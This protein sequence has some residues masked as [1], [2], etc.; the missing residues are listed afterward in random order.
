MNNN[1][2]KTIFGILKALSIGFVCIVQAQT[3]IGLY[4]LA[5]LRID[6]GLCSDCA[7]PKQAL[8]YFKNELIAT[9]T[10]AERMAGFSITKNAQQDLAENTIAAPPPLIWLGS[11]DVIEDTRLSVNVSDGELNY[12]E[13]NGNLEDTLWLGIEDKIATNLSFWDKTTTTFFKDKNVSLRG[14]IA[15]SGFIARTVWPK[16]FKLD[17]NEKLQPLNDNQNLKSLVQFENGGAK[18]AYEARLLWGDASKSQGHAVLGMI[19]NGA[20]GDDDEAHGGHFAIATGRI[21]LEGDMSNWLVNNY[22]N[23][24]SNSEKG[25]IAAPTPLDKYMA[26]VNSGQSYYRPSYMLVAVFN[27][28]HVPAQFQAATNRVY[29]HFYRNDFVYD[30]SRNNC[31]GISIDTLRNLGWNIPERGVESRLKAIGAYFLISAKERSLTKGRAI[32]DYLTTEKT[33]L[34]P[35]QT[36]DAMGNDLLQRLLNPVSKVLQN[37]VLDKQIKQDIEAIYFV[38]IPQIPSSRAFGRAPVYGFD[39]YMSRV[40]ADPKDWKTAP[41]IPN[42]FPEELKD[43]LA[44]KLEKPSLVP[45]PVAIVF[46]LLLFGLFA[47]FRKIWHL[48]TVK[49]SKK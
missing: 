36:F 2:L 14:K 23:L 47:L 20:Q 40:P 7:A 26:D 44:L 42:P 10:K 46:T 27:Q 30:H 49:F 15:M 41:A 19:L 38:R 29:Q 34:Y 9:P 3:N 48:K 4:D 45:L 33:R 5:E 43:G 12:I 37:G 21:G 6:T 18:S 28:D 35:A 25:I 32:Y 39:E 24:A 16:H 1:K 17:L 22:Y 8:W 13:Q 31:A 11:H